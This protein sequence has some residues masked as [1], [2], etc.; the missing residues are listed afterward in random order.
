MDCILF[1]QNVQ[2]KGK[3]VSENEA[4]EFANVV[5]QTKAILKEAAR[6][7]NYLTENNLLQYA[8]L[9]AKAEDIHSSYDRISK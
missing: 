6:T 9:E 4:V 2:V 7:L 5:L 1:A 8:D 3:V